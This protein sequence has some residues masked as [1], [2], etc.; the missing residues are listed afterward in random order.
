LIL[1][2]HWNSSSEREAYEHDATLLRQVVT[3]WASKSPE[4]ATIWVLEQTDGELKDAALDG[5]ARGWARKSPEG[6]TDFLMQLDD[7][8]LR[9]QLAQTMFW[10]IL[11]G[12][13]IGV[14][15]SWYDAIPHSA[16]N[17][18]NSVFPHLVERQ[19]LRNDPAALEWVK[20]R[21]PEPPN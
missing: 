18:R 14:A 19:L 10:Q 17:V 1:T 5:A 8:P 13:G 7:N 16:E 15:E 21:S 6:A 12:R 4:E 20:E 3:G 9:N 2:R 11:Y